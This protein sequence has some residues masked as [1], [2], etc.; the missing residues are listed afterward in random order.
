MVEDART[1]LPVH[2]MQT[3]AFDC[4]ADEAEPLEAHV[5]QLERLLA[6]LSTAEL[7]AE[8]A[9]MQA[10]HAQSWKLALEGDLRRPRETV[11]R[12]TR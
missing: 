2:V 6:S 7:R 3:E 8:A 12:A 5:M 1:V 11:A 4:D 10:I 9:E